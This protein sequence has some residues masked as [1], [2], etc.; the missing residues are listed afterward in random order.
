MFH[1]LFLFP[2]HNAFVPAG[3]QA[4]LWRDCQKL[5]SSKPSVMEWECELISTFT[6]QALNVSCQATGKLSTNTPPS[7]V[8][9]KCLSVL[10]LRSVLLTTH[11][12]GWGRQYL[13]L[14]WRRGHWVW[15]RTCCRHTGGI[16][17]WCM[18]EESM[19]LASSSLSWFIPFCSSSSQF[20]ISLFL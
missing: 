18:W 13:C 8:V 19:P 9:L 10:L 5:S 7:G 20:Q 11:R 1:I 17:L 3:F 14:R 4:P 12:F 6:L 2:V 15:W 16:H